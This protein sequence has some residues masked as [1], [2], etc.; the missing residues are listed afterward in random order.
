MVLTRRPFGAM[1]QQAISRIACPGFSLFAFIPFTIQAMTTLTC[2]AATLLALLTIPLVVIL[3]ATE[4]PQQR[5]RRWRRTGSTYR[6]IAERLGV[7]HTTAR[8][9]CAA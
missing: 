6:S 3:W 2:L 8:R 7:S 4:S 9:W 5:A 1:T